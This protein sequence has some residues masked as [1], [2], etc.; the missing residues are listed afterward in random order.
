MKVPELKSKQ[1]TTLA[2]DADKGPPQYDLPAAT[3]AGAIST[4]KI[5]ELKDEDSKN[6]ED[7]D[8]KFWNIVG[9]KPRFGDG[10]PDG[11]DMTTNISD[12]QTWLEERIHDKFFGGKI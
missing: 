10:V 9:W 1:A 5:E 6:T 2:S 12:Q 3:T 11:V 4:K 7:E 8:E